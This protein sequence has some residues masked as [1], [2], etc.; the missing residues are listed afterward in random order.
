LGI[1]EE[2]TQISR[3]KELIKPICSR[4]T[5]EFDLNKLHSAR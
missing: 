5:L 1:L 2:M 3:G 4:K